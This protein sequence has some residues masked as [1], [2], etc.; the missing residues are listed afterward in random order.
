MSEIFANFYT[1][2]LV[3]IKGSYTKDYNLVALINWDELETMTSYPQNLG[4]ILCIS[5]LFLE[6]KRKC[7]L[8]YKYT[9]EQNFN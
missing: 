6:N 7:S 3:L 2:S 8:R 9:K 1:R 5:F 4:I